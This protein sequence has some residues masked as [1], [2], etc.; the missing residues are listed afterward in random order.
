MLKVER[1]L[2]AAGCVRVAGLDEVGRGPL[3]GPVCAAA[4]VFRPGTRIPGVD[5]SKR[6]SHEIRVE[7][8]ERIC[9]AAEAYGIGYASAEEIDTI[10]ILQ[11]TKLAMRRALAQLPE[12]P[13]HL[14]LDALTLEHCR[15]PQRGI[16]KGDSKCFSIA[17]ASI[18]AKVARDEL[19]DRYDEL[20]P[21]YGFRQHKGYGT[22]LHWNSILAHGICS[23][24]RRTFFDPGFLGPAMKMSGRFHALCSQ[25]GARRT[26][27]E[28]DDLLAE[29]EEHRSFLP[30]REIAQLSA[31]AEARAAE[32]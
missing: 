23:L 16:V 14:L 2:H 6:I 31:L 18:I 13:D 11:A 32:L 21:Q 19:M 1:E 26:A 7:L 30:E 4:V 10:N 12:E 27:A 25:I 5:D 22:E 29:L 17:A 9:A 15:I 24:H 28:L 20:F 3:A 8:S